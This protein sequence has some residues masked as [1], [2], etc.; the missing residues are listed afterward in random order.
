MF[1]S[2]VYNVYCCAR[3]IIMQ[4]AKDLKIIMDSQGG[5]ANHA[6]RRSIRTEIDTQSL[7]VHI[8]YMASGLVCCTLQYT[9]ELSMCV[10]TRLGNQS[11]IVNLILLYT[12][13]RE[14][15]VTIK[16]HFVC[17]KNHF[18]DFST[19]FLYPISSGV[20]SKKKCTTR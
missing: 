10:I 13:S 7:N 19:Q 1:I 8:L 4:F 2:S 18:Y 5:E 15:H 17:C 6:Q 3:T 20:G 16:F 9:K 14:R 12:H 11:G